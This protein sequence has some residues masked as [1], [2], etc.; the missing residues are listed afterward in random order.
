METLAQKLGKRSNL[1]A[2]LK[3]RHYRKLDYKLPKLSE[4]PSIFAMS[5]LKL[6]LYVYSDVGSSWS[7]IAKFDN[8]AARLSQRPS[9]IV[10]NELRTWSKRLDSTYNYRDIVLEEIKCMVGKHENLWKSNDYD[11]DFMLPYLSR[12]RYKA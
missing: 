1:D 8:S 4:L 7:L 11:L 3:Y 5:D 6:S 10:S 12:N 9:N 2:T